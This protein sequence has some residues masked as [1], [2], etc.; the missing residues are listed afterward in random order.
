MTS[1]S[2]SIEFDVDRDHVM[3]LAFQGAMDNP[4]F[5]SSLIKHGLKDVY[6]GILKEW[7]VKAHAADMCN[8]PAC[9]HKSAT[10]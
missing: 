7:G 5:V 4:A 10:P 8:D 6:L 2:F 9:K 3:N 1:K